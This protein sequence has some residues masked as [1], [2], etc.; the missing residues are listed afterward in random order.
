V[1][2]TIVTWLW[3]NKYTAQDVR[4]LSFGIRRHLK[5]PF[6]FFVFSD[7]PPN[8]N[9]G[10]AIGRPILNPNLCARHCFCRLRLFDPQF[11][12]MHGIVAG[13]IVSIDLDAV[14][15]GPLDPLFDR[16]EN[17][18][19]LQGVNEV[20][21]CP[22]NASVSMLRAGAHSEIWSEFSF[23]ALQAIKFHEFHDDQGWIWHKIPDAAAFTVG[24]GVYAFQ[25]P[26]WPIGDRLPINARIVAFFGK[27]KPERYRHLPWMIEHWRDRHD[28]P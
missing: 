18:V 20:N 22:Y 2:L 28:R 21:P 10:D 16:P 4:R 26:G 13:R 3:G 1:D 7:R 14:I 5:Q 25:K 11:Q 17:F 24:D 6:R 27:R 23:E 15:T 12:A 8:E 9:F 19:I